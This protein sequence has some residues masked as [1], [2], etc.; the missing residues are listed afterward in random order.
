MYKHRIYDARTMQAI[1]LLYGGPRG[2]YLSTISFLPRI[3]PTTLVSTTPFDG[4]R[5]S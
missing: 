1:S 4:N 5:P 3:A 2:S